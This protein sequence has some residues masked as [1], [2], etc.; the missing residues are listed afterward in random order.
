MFDIGFWEIALILVLA[1]LVLGPE[2]LPGAAKKV[3]Y[4]VGKGR[5]Y[6]EGVKHE[7]SKELDATE[8]KRLL[9]NQSVQLE[10][11]KNQVNQ[12]AHDAS[13]DMHNMFDTDETEKK[14][15]PQYEILEEDDMDDELDDE[16]VGEQ[17]QSVVDKPE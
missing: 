10:E 13:S 17:H 5:R 15:Q 2:R 11:L 12:K 16:A 14:N 7:V 4:W 9:H 3:G 1:L 8:L 6:I